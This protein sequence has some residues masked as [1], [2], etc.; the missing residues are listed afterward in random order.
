MKIVKSLLFASAAVFMCACSNEVDTM[1]IGSEE[2]LVEIKLG[3]SAVSLDTRAAILDDGS[4]TIQNLA[5]WCMAKDAM[6]ENLD[7]QSIKWFGTDPEN[8]SCVIMPNVKS[9]VV[10]NEVKWDDPNAK[11]FYPVTQFYRYDFYANYPYTTDLT[12]TT[13]S[14]TANYTIDGTQD[15]LWG[16]A[17]SNERYAWSAK[18]FRANG[19]QTLENRPKLKLD[20]LL[21]RLVFFVQP[22]PAVDIEG[23]KE[24]D[25][26]FSAASTMTVDTL[27]IINAYT[28]LSVNIADFNNLDMDINSRLVRRNSTLGVL[29][30]RNASGSVVD[31]ISVPSLPSLKQQWGESI[32]LCPAQRYVVRLVLYDNTGRKHTS[33]VPLTLATSE[34]SGFERGKSYKIIITVHGPTSVTLGAALTNWDEVDGPGLEL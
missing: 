15:L 9:T 28:N 23:A 6:A 3:T 11:Y 30:L 26:D 29:N 31:P 33:E 12:H 5:V 19:G 10:A 20:H 2:G 4:G 24:E 13:N 34:T 14:V 25:L 27:Q 17:T 21:T 1:G 7:P 18:Y 32:M 22:G 16:R 8:E